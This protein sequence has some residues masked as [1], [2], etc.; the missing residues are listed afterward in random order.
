[1]HNL[2]EPISDGLQWTR[3][4]ALQLGA[5]THGVQGNKEWLGIAIEAHL[6]DLHEQTRARSGNLRILSESEMRED[7]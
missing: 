6:R 4:N 3:N 7:A 5:S 1:M 2:H